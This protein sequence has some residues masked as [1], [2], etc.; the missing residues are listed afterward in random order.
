MRGRRL[1]RW[2]LRWIGPALFLAFWYVSDHAQIRG[3]LGRARWLPLIGSAAINLA[4]LVIKA[5]RWR[6]IMK[7]Q[8]IDYGFAPSV[9]AYTIASAIASWTPGRL[10]DFTKAFSVSREKGIS[11]GRAASSV[12]ADRLLDAFALTL[13][14]AAGAGF[15][16]GPVGG[17][18]TWCLV[19]L[20]GVIAWVLYRWTSQAGPEKASAAFGR[21]GLARAG[22]ELGDA[23]AGLEQMATPSGRR[24]AL[25]AF[26]STLA[27]TLLTFLQGYL[28]A[29]S[30]GVPVAFL[31][32][33]AGLA[34]ASIA[35]LLPL[36]ISGIGIREATLAFY[37]GPGGI[38]LPQ[39]VSFSVAFLLV[40]SGSAAL[41]GALA[42]MFWRAPVTPPHGASAAAPAAPAGE[43]SPRG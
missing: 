6:E 13:V 42:Y 14:A 22:R 38:S 28:V 29:V 15:L 36:T 4:L 40:V 11:F 32:L 7:L 3:L 34:G 27:S 41:Y 5:W 10:G 35:A 16:L 26:V 9:R 21:V 17:T 43:G 30:L 20:A 12:I 39:V 25:V 31:R 2:A 8:A 19:A 33:A 18:V 24:P 1:G 23:I 37:L